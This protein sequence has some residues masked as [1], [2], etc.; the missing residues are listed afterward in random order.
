MSFVKALMKAKKYLTIGPN[1]RSDSQTLI[2]KIEKP[3][4]TE[5]FLSDLKYKLDD[6]TDTLEL[7]DK[8][9]IDALAYIRK[10]KPDLTPQVRQK[11]SIPTMEIVR[12]R[13]EVVS[14]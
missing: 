8:N 10:E 13:Q 14:R 1:Y 5:F 9:V 7:K 11:A 4:P 12:E 6:K 3:L 2:S